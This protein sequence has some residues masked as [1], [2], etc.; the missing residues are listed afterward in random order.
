VALPHR[1]LIPGYF[2]DRLNKLWAEN[3]D[4]RGR[5]TD[6]YPEDQGYNGLGESSV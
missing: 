2:L 3:V 4:E 6:G 1:T 5:R